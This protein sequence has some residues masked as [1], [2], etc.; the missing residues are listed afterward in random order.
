M[1]S[2][3]GVMEVWITRSMTTATFKNDACQRPHQES[4]TRQVTE[5]TRAS[6]WLASV[7]PC[8]SLPCPYPFNMGNVAYAGAQLRV[9][10]GSRTSYRMPYSLDRVVHQVWS[11]KL[12]FEKNRG[13]GTSTCGECGDTGARAGRWRT[14]TPPVGMAPCTCCEGLTQG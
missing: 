10:T 4:P 13:D 7:A 2:Q 1:S 14:D 6:R 5:R 12:V 11:V 8:G 9:S 3:L